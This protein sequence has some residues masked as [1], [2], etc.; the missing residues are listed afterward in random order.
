[1]QHARKR[2]PLTQDI[3]RSPGESLREIIDDMRLDFMSYIFVMSGMPLFFYATY[4]EQRSAGAQ[5]S[6]ILAGIYLLAGIGV[7][8][9]AVLKVMKLMLRLQSHRLGLDAEL[10]VV[11]E[12]NQLLRDGYR[13]FHD[14]P[15]ERC[16]IDHV[17]ERIR[18]HVENSF[19]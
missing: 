6:I 17:V 2:T 8:V 19:A 1:M 12:L 3:L 9:F 7:F 4:L 10:A 16:N 14:L 5:L 18:L 15:A 13:V 11:Q